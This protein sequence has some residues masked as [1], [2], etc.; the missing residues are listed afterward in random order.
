MQMRRAIGKSVLLLAAVV[1]LIGL[2]AGPSRPLVA[3][4][5]LRTGLGGIPLDVPLRYQVAK[6][7]ALDAA[8]EHAFGAR[9]AA[10]SDT[11]VV[12]DPNDDANG[13]E[14]GAAYVFQ[15]GQ[16]DPGGWGQVAKLTA[17]DAGVFHKFGCAVAICGD[18]V[19][20]GAYAIP[21]GGAAYVFQRDQ[22]GPD[23][24]GQ[25]ARIT[26]HNTT[27]GDHFGFAL[28]LDGDTLVVGAYA[29]GDYDGQA[30]IFYRHQGGPDAWGQVAH[31]VPGDVFAYDYFG[32]AV[33]ISGDTV[34]AGSPGNDGQKG[35]AYIFQRDQGGPDAWGQV[36][37]LTAADGVQHDF[38]GFPVAISGD[39]ALA[40]ASERSPVGLAYVFE[41]DQGG[42]ETWSQVTTLAAGDLVP[43]DAFGASLSIAG[44]VA[45]VGAPGYEPGGAAYLFARDQSGPGAWKQVARLRA[46]DPLPGAA[47]GASLAIAGDLLAVGA[48]G[49][50]PGGS[51]YLFI[52]ANTPPGVLQFS[53]TP[54]PVAEGTPT[55]L[56]GSFT[57]P[58]AGE[59]F[60]VTVAWGDGSSDLAGASG[61]PPTYTF[62][63]SHTYADGPASFAIAVA[64][65]DLAGGSSSATGTLGVDNVPPA[66]G[67][68]PDRSATA[69]EPLTVTVAFTDPGRLDGHTVAIRWAGTISQTVPL[70]P[71]V[72]MLTVPYTYSLPGVYTVTVAVA[73]DDGAADG[74]SFV[75]TVQQRRYTAYLPLVYR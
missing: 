71:G 37:K 34:I 10:Y 61:S 22:G 54:E 24:W 60:T 53:T 29:G 75:V 68:L 58:D 25:V 13:T 35:A 26:G 73:D 20:V 45:A 33:A 16:G 46:G 66:L 39:T 32:S 31:I 42:P 18:F 8:P 69:G 7:K 28:A 5:G 49:D 47:F 63:L 30:Y 2:P 64:V 57:D 43:G 11:V 38:F 44:D 67:D 48:P 50:E 17:S 59:S 40:S 21:P 27:F 12:G 72:A 9:M 23:A 56:S 62:A 3:A 14:S 15:A 70:S 1:L 41:R 6:I 74:G 19:V 4:A 65:T 52:L 51:A 55:L 36:A